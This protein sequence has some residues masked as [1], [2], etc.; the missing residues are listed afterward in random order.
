[1]KNRKKASLAGWQGSHLSYLNLACPPWFSIKLGI[2]WEALAELNY[3]G[4]PRCTRFPLLNLC[5][6]EECPRHSSHCHRSSFCGWCW[7]SDRLR[8]PA[9]GKFRIR[10]QGLNFLFLPLGEVPGP[11]L[12]GRFSKHSEWLLSQGSAIVQLSQNIIAC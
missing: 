11:G 1:M 6:P 4:L 7:E 12:W 5:N 10:V 2:T 8:E 3:E 9:Q